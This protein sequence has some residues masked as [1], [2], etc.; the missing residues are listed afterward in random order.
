M[1][2]TLVFL[3][4]AFMVASSVPAKDREVLRASIAW[5]DIRQR[6]A[7]AVI[8]ENCAREYWGDPTK[9]LG[10]RIGGIPAEWSEIVGV[11][12]NG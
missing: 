8:S 3:F 9:A 10:K 11:V 7:I 2:K 4:V 5:P 12:G 1:R 6:A